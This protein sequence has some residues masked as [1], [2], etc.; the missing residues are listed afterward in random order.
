MTISKHIATALVGAGLMAGTNAYAGTVV[1][2][3]SVA[4]DPDRAAVTAAVDAFEK[5]H[6]DIDVDINFYDEESNKTA[7]RNWL[8]TSPPDIVKWYA[9]NKM[10][11]LVEPGLLADVSDIWT[12]EEKTEF[13]PG[14]VDSISVDGKQYGVPTSYSTWA[15]YYRTDLFEKA[16]VT[17]PIATFD[18]LVAACT[19]FRDNGIIPIALGSKGAWPLAG[20]FDYIDLRLNGYKFHMD[21]MNGKVAWSDDKVKAVFA[22]WKKLVDADCFAENHT[23]LAWREGLAKMNQG[24]AAMMLMGN[25]L[26]ASL[27]PESEPVTGAMNFPVINADIPRAEDAPIETYHIPAK[28]KNI[29]EAK[30]F[31]AFLMEPSTQSLMSEI[32]PVLPANPEASPPDVR[33]LKDS[34]ELAAGAEYYAQ[35][36]DRDTDSQV[37][38]VAMDGF[39]EFLVHPERL[40]RILANIDRAQQRAYP[41]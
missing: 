15:I 35:F 30:L 3:A 11:Q 33:L 16:G 39:Q 5:I 28:A 26:I 24:E 37:A 7:I 29:P 34:A 1:F 6:P 21:L 38:T 13:G 25:Y 36:I 22:E 17:A 27:T 18:D 12:D 2:N 14:M 10:V 19:T 31:L 23:S 9:G 32:Y 40:D 8:T 20:W 4:S 41:Q